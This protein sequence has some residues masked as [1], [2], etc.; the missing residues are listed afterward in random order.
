MVSGVCTI[1]PLF[2][3]QQKK[4]VNELAN[5]KNTLDF[6]ICWNNRRFIVTRS[7]N[8][9]SMQRITAKN[10]YCL[11]SW[12]FHT[13]STQLKQRQYSRVSRHS[14]NFVKFTQPSLQTLNG[15]VPDFWTANW[16]ETSAKLILALFLFW[17]STIFFWLLTSLLLSS[18]SVSIVMGNIVF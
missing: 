18:H 2:A 13:Q 6:S 16:A 3:N 10:R 8:V 5:N 15:N 1:V 4:A 14:M 9:Q 7:K 12:E 17:I 11:Y